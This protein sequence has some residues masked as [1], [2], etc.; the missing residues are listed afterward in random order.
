G[1]GQGAARRGELR[2]E[3]RRARTRS[4]HH[5]R[6]RARGR[7]DRALPRAPRR[8][9]DDLPP[10]VAGNGP[11][12]SPAVDPAARPKSPVEV[13][14]QLTKEI[15]AGYVS[16]TAVPPL[17]TGLARSILSSPGHSR[18]WHRACLGS[19]IERQT[20]DSANA[21]P[22]DESR[23]FD[24]TRGSGHPPSDRG[25]RPLAPPRSDRQGARLVAKAGR[26]GH[27]GEGRDL[28]RAR[29]RPGAV[30]F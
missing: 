2:R 26:R 20:R 27:R 13:P 21:G 19:T 15:H 23:W 6:S 14:V 7:R 22:R 5:R 8:H 29:R 10:A 24:S 28:R 30:W 1:A 3:L 17:A 25:G 16:L 18:W 9:D 12:K 4:V 11:G